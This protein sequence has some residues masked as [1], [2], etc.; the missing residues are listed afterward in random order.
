MPSAALA[1]VEGEPTEA[2]IDRVQS[3]VLSTQP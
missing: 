3:A 2:R 1:R